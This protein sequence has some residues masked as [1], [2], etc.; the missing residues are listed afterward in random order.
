MALKKECKIYAM[1]VE[2]RFHPMI[3]IEK[4]MKR[5]FH[6]TFVLIIMMMKEK[7]VSESVSIKLS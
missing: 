3:L 5:V 4:N 6:A 1:L 2:Y 7:N